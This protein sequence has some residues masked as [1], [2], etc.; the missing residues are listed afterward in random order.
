VQVSTC[1]FAVCVCVCAFA[2]CVCVCA[3]ICV[4]VCVYVCVCACVHASVLA[5]VY[6]CVSARVHVNSLVHGSLPARP[7][8]IAVI[9]NNLLESTPQD[10]SRLC[11]CLKYVDGCL[12]GSL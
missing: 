2:V 5:C 10:K 3:S 6:V 11:S 8:R 12:D 7:E 4:C 9:Q 1:A